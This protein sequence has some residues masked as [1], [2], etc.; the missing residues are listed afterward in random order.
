MVLRLQGVAQAA[1]GRDAH[2]SGKNGGMAVAGAA[3]GHE[4][5]NLGLVQLQGLGGGQIVRRQDH[6]LL[7]IDAAL[8]NAHEVIEKPLGHILNVRGSCLHVRIV[9]GG[10]HGGKLLARH[11]HGVLRVALLFLHGAG[12]GIHIILVLDEHSMGFKQ[13]G[14]LIAGFLPAVLRQHLQLGNGFLLCL[15]Q[16]GFL[17]LHI[18]GELFDLLL[19]TLIEIKVS[20]ENA[21]GNALT[22]NYNHSDP[23]VRS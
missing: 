15:S 12:D 23:P 7:G 6:R 3:L 5:Q 9:H 13:D 2:G 8:H 4:A 22:L 18:R 11:H 19:G 20:L 21:L 17:R 16:T 14:G 10:K 1:D